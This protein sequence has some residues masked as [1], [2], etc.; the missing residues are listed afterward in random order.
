MALGCPYK[1]SPPSPCTFRLSQRGLDQEP[2]EWRVLAGGDLLRHLRL[3]KRAMRTTLGILR[4]GALQTTLTRVAPLCLQTSRI[5]TDDTHNGL[6]Q[7]HN[8][9]P[10]SSEP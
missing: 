4:S 2:Q 3:S 5:N 9:V 1:P 10:P 6:A 7:A 8:L